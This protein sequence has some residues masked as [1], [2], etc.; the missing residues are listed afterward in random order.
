MPFDIPTTLGAMVEALAAQK[1]LRGAAEALAEEHK[2]HEQILEE[3]ILGAL[4]EQ[5]LDKGSHGGFSFGRSETVVPQVQDWD[6]FHKYIA[7]KKWFHLLERRPSAAACR[8]VFEMNGAIP[9]VIPFVKVKLS[10]RKTP[11]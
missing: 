1:V 5:G 7:R 4:K 3:A 11:Q 6:V 8:E 9:G 2:G 10:F